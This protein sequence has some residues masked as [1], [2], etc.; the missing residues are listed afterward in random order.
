MR[1]WDVRWKEDLS[2]AASHIAFQMPSGLTHAPAL[3]DRGFQRHG[4]FVWLF[5]KRLDVQNMHLLTN[6][7]AGLIGKPWNPPTFTSS[8]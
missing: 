5:E 2:I 6:S 7:G 4:S 3:V 1:G 8:S